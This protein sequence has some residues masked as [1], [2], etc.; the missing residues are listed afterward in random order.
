MAEV[1]YDIWRLSQET[2]EAELAAMAVQQAAFEVR[3]TISLLLPVGEVDEIWLRDGIASLARQVYPEWE[4][5][6][7]Q[8]GARARVQDMLPS[9]PALLTRIRAIEPGAA[10]PTTGEALEAALNAASGEYVAILGEGDELAP[11]ALF[12]VVEAVQTSNADIVYTDEDSIDHLGRHTDPVLKPDWSPDQMLTSPYVG[13]LCA[14]R[15]ELL[16]TDPGGPTVRSGELTEFDTMLRAAEQATTVVHVPHV[17][18]HRRL[19]ASAP[20]PDAARLMADDSD[21]LVNVVETALARRGDDARVRPVARRPAVRLLRE[22]DWGMPI[23]VIVQTGRRGQNVA[24]LRQLLQRSSAHE[25]IAASPEPM[26]PG[27]DDMKLIVDRSLARAANRAAADATGEVLLFIDGR[28]ALGQA[29]IGGLDEM[30]AQAFRAGTGAVSGRVVNGDGTLRHGGTGRRPRG[31]TGVARPRARARG[32]GDPGHA[33]AAQSRRRHRRAAG[34]QRRHVR[35]GRRVRRGSSRQPLPRPRSLTAPRGARVAQ[36]LHALRGPLDQGP[37][38]RSRRPGG[39]L[40]VGALGTGAR[41][42]ALQPLAAERRSP[43]AAGGGVHGPPLRRGRAVRILLTTH[44]FFPQALRGDRGGRSRRRARVA[45][46]RPRRPCA[47][48]RPGFVQR[49]G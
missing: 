15:R 40:H 11:D 36:R 32:H 13:R 27:V 4:L 17:L 25:V 2:G 19:V 21:G 16:L 31:P 38:P 45:T 41:A 26:R 42:P 18:Y 49:L 14:V 35:G 24:L 39:R 47:H 1:D 44:Q 34:D 20:G 30:V 23:S 3:P 9:D 29:G 12:R 10:D 48:R 43:S 46:P 5:C 7:Y 6:V 33:R 37:A 22:R 8:R 28:A